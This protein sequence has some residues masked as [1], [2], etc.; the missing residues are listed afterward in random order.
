MRVCSFPQVQREASQVSERERSVQ[1][2]L[3]WPN[4]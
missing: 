4:A 2:A 1:R 3:Y